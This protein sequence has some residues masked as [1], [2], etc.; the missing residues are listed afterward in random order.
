VGQRLVEMLAERGAERVISYDIVP[1]PAEAWTHPAIEWV[2]GDVCNLEHL[3]RVVKG[4]DC[5]WHL[6]AA[7]GPFH[8][9]STHVKARVNRCCGSNG[10]GSRVCVGGGR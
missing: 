2:V 3:V 9:K 1:P 8:P 6:A 5:V 7:V 10:M 4:A